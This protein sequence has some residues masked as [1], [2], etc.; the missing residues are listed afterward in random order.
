MQLRGVAPR[1][2]RVLQRVILQSGERDITEVV[3]RRT[4]A[5]P[6][7]AIGFHKARPPSAPSHD[8]EFGLKKS[9]P[10]SR[11]QDHALRTLRVPLSPAAAYSGGAL[12]Y[13]GSDG[14]TM[15][16][17]GSVGALTAH[18]NRVLHC[19]TPVTRGVRDVLYMLVK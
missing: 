1:L 7:L 18:D 3:V 6:G 12:T 10:C 2:S 5:Q 19:A 14:E 8:S 9:Q 17:D 13:V 4:I 16:A 11:T 15:Q